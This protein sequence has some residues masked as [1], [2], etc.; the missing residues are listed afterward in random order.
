MICA[1]MPFVV[2]PLPDDEVDGEAA[3]PHQPGR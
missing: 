1:S 2:L 3:L